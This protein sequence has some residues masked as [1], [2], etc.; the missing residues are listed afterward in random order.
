MIIALKEP[1]MNLTGKEERVGLKTNG[2][3]RS[4]PD[5]LEWEHRLQDPRLPEN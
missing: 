5:P 4:S 1:G 2:Q 3:K